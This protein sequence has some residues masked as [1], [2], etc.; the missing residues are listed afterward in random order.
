MTAAN[1]HLVN[2]TLIYW[3]NLA[4]PR[5]TVAVDIASASFCQHGAGEEQIAA[6][7]ALPAIAFADKNLTSNIFLLEMNQPETP[8][9]A[10]GVEQKTGILNRLCNSEKQTI[11][12][13][14]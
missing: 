9:L 4:G 2:V 13:C 5:T 1:S 8:Y 11:E 14:G 6:C 10:G 12:K 3:E 7:A